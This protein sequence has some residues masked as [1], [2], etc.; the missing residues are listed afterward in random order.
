LGLVEK[1]DGVYLVNRH[2]A[3]VLPFDLETAIGDGARVHTFGD[4]DAWRPL[5]FIPWDPSVQQA[6]E[7]K[8]L[9]QRIL[10]ERVLG[11]AISRVGKQR[12]PGQV[13]LHLDTIL[14][15][16]T[17]NLAKLWR[18]RRDIAYVLTA[19]R[20]FLENAIRVGAPRLDA[21]RDIPARALRI[22]IAS[23]EDAEVLRRAL[24]ERKPAEWLGSS[25]ARQPSLFEQE[26]V[27]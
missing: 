24:E 21:R 13:D 26:R 16:A 20:S 27:E 11:S 8:A 9:W 12:A 19:I 7:E 22:P 5:Y 23:R 1:S 18:S 10:Y 14:D 4:R 6:A 15:E 3:G 25:E 2:P 17:F